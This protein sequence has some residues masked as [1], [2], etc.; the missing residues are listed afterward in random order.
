MVTVKFEMTDDKKTFVMSVE[1][2]AESAEKGKDVVCACVSFA[3]YTAAQNVTDLYNLGGLKKKPTIKLDEGNAVIT[4]KPKKDAYDE[5][6]HIFRVIRRG[7]E[8][9]TV[10]FPDYVRMIS[11]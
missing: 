4:C 8:L 9:L 10:N 3:A 5:A 2:H 11:A 1:G 7:I 6:E